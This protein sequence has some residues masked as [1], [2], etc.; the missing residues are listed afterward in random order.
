MPRVPIYEQRMSPSGP[1]G[2]GPQPDTAIAARALP[3][4]AGGLDTL[5]AALEQRRE[6]DAAAWSA[7]TLAE[8][9]SEW[10]QSLIKRKQEAPA[11][12]PNFTPQLLT[13]FDA[14]A[15]KTVQMAPTRHT[16]QFLEQRFAALR[17]SL[18][19]DALAFEAASASAHA[20]DIAKQSIDSARNELQVRPDVFNERLAER[21]ALID[22]MRLPAV[23]KQEL[24]EHAV[25]S[26]SHDAVLGLIQ[27]DPRETLKR[28]NMEP[29]KTGVASI[30]ALA[31]DD[32]I[33]LRS[34]AETEVRRLDELAKTSLREARQ[35]MDDRLRDIGVASQL[36]IPIEDVPQEAELKAI[37]GDHEGSQHYAAVQRAVKLSSTVANLHTMSTS[38]LISTVSGPPS[39]EEIMKNL[40]RTT[41]PADQEKAYRAWLAK[42]GMTREAG[43]NIDENFTGRDYDLRGFFK[44]YGPVDVNVRGGQHFT[45]E[46]KLPNHETFSDQSMYAT[47]PARALAGHWEGDKYIPPAST[48]DFGPPHEVAGAAEQAQL[49]AFVGKSVQRIL[50][51][52]QK[53]PAGY[54][55]R[56]SPAAKEAWTRFMQADPSDRAAATQD[57]LHTVRAERERLGIPGSDV[58]PNEYA[59]T[60]ADE[61]EAPA[62]AE[63]LATTIE[64]ESMRW[65]AAWPQVYRQLAP[66]ISDAA[67]VIGSG[68][69]RSVA[70]AIASLSQLEKPQLEGML[71]P[72]TKWA[73]LEAA[74]DSELED[75]QRSFSSDP[76]A[77]RVSHAFRDQTI[78]L[79]AQNMK[80]GASR[81]DAVAKAYRDLVGSEY[82]LIEFQGVTIRAPASIDPAI[83]RDGARGA[84]D[85]L[86]LTSMAIDVPPGSPFTAEEYLVQFIEHVRAHGYWLTRPDGTGVRLYLDGGPVMD[87]GG[88]VERTWQQ[89]QAL[90]GQLE[91]QRAQEQRER[92]RRRQEMR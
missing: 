8:A 4:L 44:K 48:G 24:T 68:V 35:A 40:Q 17:G 54:L 3:A 55:V 20:T 58:L 88:P 1:L 42:I 37:Y 15:K 81:A 53:D 6:E 26:M 83:V 29:G 22:S 91:E 90:H 16:R 47:G 65:G 67:L 75:F 57:Y 32:R 50:D 71:P 45:D 72:S 62:S 39:K 11:G 9:Q 7:K 49:H 69:P 85:G 89:L 19:S 30:D 21:A 92:A 5:G 13:D 76:G 2:P 36:G 74:V 33:Q 87:A 64:S 38:E 23:R 82:S 46:F 70:V 31:P 25:R 27:R 43:Y 10:T 41:L 60:V 79:A 14:Y 28:L 56:Y 51:E 78:K 52:R 61:I 59:K 63:Q 12:A 73:D 80:R 34:A 86:Q 18:A 66:H 77:V 84:L